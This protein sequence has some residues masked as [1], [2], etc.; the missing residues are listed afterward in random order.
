MNWFLDDPSP[1]PSIF[2][3][4]HGLPAIG[5]YMN[6]SSLLDEEQEAGPVFTPSESFTAMPRVV[7]RISPL[8]Q[9]GQ[10]KWG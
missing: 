5:L 8:T 10:A 3:I 4:H 6:E 2:L 9:T 7:H 1:I